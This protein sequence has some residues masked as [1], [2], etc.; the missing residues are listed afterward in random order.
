MNELSNLCSKY[1][2]RTCKYVSTLYGNV[3]DPIK[4]KCNLNESSIIVIPWY[5]KHIEDVD[6]HFCSEYKVK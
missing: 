3:K 5:N 6:K 2:C 4:A 1:N